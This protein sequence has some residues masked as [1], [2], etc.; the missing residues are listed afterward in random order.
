MDVKEFI[1]G[2]KNHPVLFVGAGLSL[3]YLEGAFS[4]EDLLSKV[5]FE[6]RGIKSIS[7]I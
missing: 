6:L 3:R 7:L 1:G 2:Y 4:W 5:C